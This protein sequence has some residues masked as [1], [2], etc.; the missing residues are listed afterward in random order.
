MSCKSVPSALP[1]FEI[2]SLE[3]K[4]LKNNNNNER[5]NKTKGKLNSF[6]KRT[7]KD[8]DTLIFRVLEHM[9][10][11]NK[12]K[13]KKEKRRNVEGFPSFLVTPSNNC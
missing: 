1:H 9:D 12:Q 4:I 2:K 13:E 5:K 7:Y 3:M 10:L 11:K 6:L 8:W